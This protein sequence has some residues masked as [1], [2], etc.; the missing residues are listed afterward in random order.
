M[1][2]PKHEIEAEAIL[3]QTGSRVT[4]GRVVVLALLLHT[5]RAL[6]HGEVHAQIGRS[7]RI[8]RVTVYRVL[9]WLTQQGIAHRVSADDRVWRFTV[10]TAEHSGTHPHFQCNACG[11]VI[12][13]EETA[14]VPPVAL[15]AG[16]RGD[17]VELT[18]KGICAYCLPRKPRPIRK[19]AS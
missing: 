16:F 10:E 19:R 13:L 2:S 9:D 17:E 14:D 5:N 18:V 7:E 11:N 4:R 15:P 1:S 6:T 12:C 8:D 3:R